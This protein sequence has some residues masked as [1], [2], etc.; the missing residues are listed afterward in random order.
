MNLKCIYIAIA[1]YVIWAAHSKTHLQKAPGP[2]QLFFPGYLEAV[3]RYPRSNGSF[4]LIDVE[5]FTFSESEIEKYRNLQK[6][7]AID[8]RKVIRW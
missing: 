2:I 1:I 8:M 7:I 3:M 5:Y 6:K 4:W